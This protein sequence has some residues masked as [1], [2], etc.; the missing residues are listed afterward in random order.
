MDSSMSNEERERLKKLEKEGGR[1]NLDLFLRMNSGRAQLIYELLQNADD[2]KAELIRFKLTQDELNIHHDGKDFETDDIEAITDY[3]Y[4]NKTVGSIGKFGIGFKSVFRVTATPH[5]FSGKFNITI[6][7]YRRIKHI[8]PSG[9]KELKTLI[10]LPFDYAESDSELLKLAQNEAFGTIRNKLETINSRILLFLKNVKKIEWE[11]PYSKGECS[12]SEEA[13]QQGKELETTDVKLTSSEGVQEYMVLKRPITVKD[14]ELYVEVAFR[15]EEQEGKKSIIA[16][17]DTKLVAF[18]PTEKETSLDFVIQGPYD[19]VLQ[20][21]NIHQIKENEQNQ[22]IL[23]ETG[24]LVANALYV[25]KERG[26]LN[27]VT[28]NLFP[29]RNSKKETNEIYAALYDRVAEELSDGEFLP[30]SQG[31]YTTPEKALLADGQWLTKFLN[32]NNGLKELFPEGASWLDTSITRDRNVA[33][34]K[35]DNL[36]AYLVDNFEVET[37]GFSE[38]AEKYATKPFLQNR[39]D[40]WMVE[41]YKE[42]LKHSSLW[43]RGGESRQRP[44]DY[45]PI[46]RLERTLDTDAGKNEHIKPF[47]KDGKIQVYCPT[48]TQSGFPTVKGVFFEDD[49]SCEFLDA[50][51]IKE[52]DS[53]ETIK[54]MMSHYEKT[55]DFSRVNDFEGFLRERNLDFKGYLNELKKIL[56]EYDEIPLNKDEKKE[57]KQL[58]LKKRFLPVIKN[59]SGNRLYLASPTEVYFDS[60]DLR[61][62]FKGYE[63]YFLSIPYE[64]LKSDKGQIENILRDLGVTGSPRFVRKSPRNLSQEENLMVPQDVSQDSRKII[65][66]EYEGLKN[67]MLNSAGSGTTIDRSRT[68]WKLL[69]SSLGDLESEQ[70]EWA[71]RKKLV[72]IRRNKITLYPTV[73]MGTTDSCDWLKQYEWLFDKNGTR[74]KPVDIMDSELDDSYERQGGEI[75]L[76]MSTLEIKEFSLDEF[77]KGLLITRKEAEEFIRKGIRERKSADDSKVD[78]ENTPPWAP[79]CEPESLSPFTRNIVFDGLSREDSDVAESYGNPNE[80]EEFSRIDKRHKKA[81][82]EWGKRLVCHYLDQKYE[83]PES[84]EETSGGF[85]VVNP[86]GKLIEYIEVKSTTQKFLTSIQVPDS[87][88]E[89]ARKLGRKYSFYIVSNAGLRDAERIGVLRDPIGSWKEDKLRAHPVLL[90]LP[91]HTQ[92]G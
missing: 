68:L 64:D 72:R 60:D 65:E 20:R 1:V 34:G 25:I 88:W 37:L 39:S 14:T 79:E 71:L 77:T 83:G 52:L 54:E 89:C 92:D 45:K 35:G 66:C 76:L 62:F 29:V 2:A 19:L 36:W 67:F 22:K 47:G 40:S 42:L 74:R 15:L 9:R 80:E 63:A 50:L 5:I 28:L 17:K 24:K 70:A 91:K 49:K 13:F 8:P 57:L 73:D 33:M 10:N 18:F 55:R 78:D 59:E 43:S 31:G 26:Y 11:T 16:E 30:T 3:G 38:F 87:Q 32:E 82:G 7:D 23:Y 48:S 61:E 75:D 27:V 90:K 53:Y 86:S 58:L 81:I 6:V 41:F 51:G 56:E 44:L 46:I 85:K 12:K 21:E 4:S 84:I 69:V